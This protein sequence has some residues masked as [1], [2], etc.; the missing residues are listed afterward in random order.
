MLREALVV[1][2]LDGRLVISTLGHTLCCMVHQCMHFS[3]TGNPSS[4]HPLEPHSLDIGGA[5]IGSP[6]HC[7]IVLTQQ[8]NV[9]LGILLGLQKCDCMCSI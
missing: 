5:H 2:V 4:G 8:Q 3:V 1:A 6:G 9:S 7:N